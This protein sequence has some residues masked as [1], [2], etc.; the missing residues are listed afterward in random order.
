MTANIRGISA[1]LIANFF[2]IVCP[3]ARW[4]WDRTAIDRPL[5]LKVIQGYRAKFRRELSRHGE[6]RCLDRIEIDRLANWRIH[7]FLLNEEALVILGNA[8]ANLSGTAWGIGEAATFDP[9]EFV[10][11]RLERLEKEARLTGQEP[12]WDDAAAAGE[13]SPGSDIQD[14][15]FCCQN[16]NPRYHYRMIN[17]VIY[18]RTS[19]DCPMSAEAQIARLTSSAVDQ[20]WMVGKVFVDRPLAWR[21]GRGRRPG[22]DALRAA[23]KCGDFQTVFLWS[24]DRIGRPLVEL[25][26]FLEMCRTADVGL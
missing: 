18:A 3:A 14:L 23:I 21:K 4:S 22:E 7:F 2:T 12:W 25:V 20:G 15:T 1:N 19:P 13:A 11:S 8:V 17:A 9:R 26:G 10:I 5:T 16:H 24:I 6:G